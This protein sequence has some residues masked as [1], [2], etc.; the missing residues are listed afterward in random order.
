MVSF[1][2]GDKVFSYEAMSDEDQLRKEGEKYAGQIF[3]A[4]IKREKRPE[5]IIRGIWLK[6]AYTI[7]GTHYI[8]YIN[9]EEDPIGFA[10][11]PLLHN[12]WS[13]ISLNHKDYGV[14]DLIIGAEKVASSEAQ[15]IVRFLFEEEQ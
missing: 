13:N 12:L 6:A 7:T 8:N 10:T 1:K 9:L 3:T 4:K 5:Q 11:A 14:Q 15:D 2:P